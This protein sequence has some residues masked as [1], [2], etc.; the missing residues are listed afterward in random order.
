MAG[1]YWVLFGTVVGAVEYCW[2]P[3][4]DTLSPIGYLQRVS[5][6]AVG[7]L[8]WVS[9]VPMMALV[10]TVGAPLS[11]GIETKAIIELVLGFSLE[12]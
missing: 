3:I 7:Y 12:E 11:T 4:V 1:Y 10:G 2:V 8:C 6:G 9:L 5:L